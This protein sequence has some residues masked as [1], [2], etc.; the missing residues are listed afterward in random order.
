MTISTVDGSQR[1][2][3]R[4]AGFMYLFAMVTALIGFYVRS[5][6]IVADA[7]QTARNIVAHEGLFRLSIVSEL[8]TSVADIVL[9][10]AL[11]VVLRPISRGLALLAA[12][13]RV[14]ETSILVIATLT[15]F[16]VLQ[17]LSGADYLRGFEAD[18]LQA[19]AKVAIGV[20][21]A[22]YNVCFVFLGLGSTVF[23][24]L[25]HRSRYIPRPLA[26]WGVFAS[27]LFVPC[28]LGIILFPDLAKIVM[29]AYWAPLGIFEVTMGFL[30]LIRGLRSP[31]V[32]EPAGR[33]EVAAI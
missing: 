19:L 20:H 15:S 13:W 14:I 9:I 30:L 18:R 24:Y 25:W 3:A 10:V 22:A 2:A 8:L 31:A 5:R 1:K 4:V 12:S 26:A 33:A 23:A 11:F 6:F 17:L 27:A 32:A 21:G 16:E 28:A 7:G 29:P